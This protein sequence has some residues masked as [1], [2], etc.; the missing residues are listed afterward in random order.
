[1]SNPNLPGRGHG[2]YPPFFQSFQKEM[3][4]MLDHLRGTAVP[5]PTEDGSPLMLA[6]DVAETDTGLEISADVPGVDEA[7]LDVSVHGDTLVI[8]GQKG[9]DREEKH[10]DYHLVERS[11]GRFRRHIPLGFVP[12]EGA[13]KAEFA[14]GVLKLQIDRPENAPPG[15]QKIN[16]GAS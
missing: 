13:V 16:I 6:V 11:Y 1:M 12:E 7:D 10:K 5:Q 2:M 8:K 4:Q 15:V 14:N 9:A 3:A